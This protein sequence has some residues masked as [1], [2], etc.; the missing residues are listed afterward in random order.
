MPIISRTAKPFLHRSN[1]SDAILNT[2]RI[3]EHLQPRRCTRHRLHPHVPRRVP[4]IHEPSGTRRGTAG[5]VELVS[6]GK[7]LPLRKS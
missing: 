2:S 7:K 6:S 5:Q 3:H 1:L 4:G